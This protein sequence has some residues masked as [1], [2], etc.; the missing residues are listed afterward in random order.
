M[1]V[2]GKISKKELE[3]NGARA[4]I[5]SVDIPKGKSGLVHIWGRNDTTEAQQ[6]GISWVVLDPDGITRESYSVWESWPYTGAGKEHEFI[7]DR[8]TLDKSG[9]WR[10]NVALYMD[11]SNPTVVD[12]YYDI[13]CSVVPS[14]PECSQFRIVDY[15]TV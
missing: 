7:G 15:A 4:I 10:I 2:S 11:P 13:L 14:E 8:F 6:M 3:Y 9:T 5:P 1:A 12:S